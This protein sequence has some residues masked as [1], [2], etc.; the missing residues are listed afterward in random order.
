MMPNAEMVVF[1]ESGYSPQKEEKE[2]FE[3]LLREFLDPY[4]PVAA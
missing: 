1:E 3:R 2:K 4:V